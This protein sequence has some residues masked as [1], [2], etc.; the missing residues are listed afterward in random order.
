MVLVLGHC[1]HVAVVFDSA[2]SINVVFVS[3]LSVDVFPS[4]FAN[5]FWLHLAAPCAGEYRIPNLHR[6]QAHS[7]TQTT[8]PSSAGSVTKNVLISVC[9]IWFSYKLD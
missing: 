5:G 8:A 2:P 4:D 7:A 6:L 3:V 1:H 9:L